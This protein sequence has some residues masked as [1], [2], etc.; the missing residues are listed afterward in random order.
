[1]RSQRLIISRPIITRFRGRCSQ[2]DTHPL[3][4]QY[5]VFWRA[6]VSQPTRLDP[7]TPPER[8]GDWRQPDPLFFLNF[9]LRNGKK[10]LTEYKPV[11]KDWISRNIGRYCA[12]C[13]RLRVRKGERERKGGAL[14][15][16][17]ACEGE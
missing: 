2:L 11:L 14:L 10:F 7:L 9:S 8:G 1:M 3:I 16:V 13:A 5:I 12:S 4:I 17:R 6:G 15:C